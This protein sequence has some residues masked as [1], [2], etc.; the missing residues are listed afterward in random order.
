[1][2]AP[3]PG[4]H[5]GQPQLGQ[6]RV[7]G[8]TH[9]RVHEPD[10]SRPGLG[11]QPGDDAGLEPGYDAIL[12]G[13]GRVHEH[14]DVG[15]LTHGGG[16][17]QDRHRGRGQPGQAPPEHVPDAFR[18]FGHD[19]QPTLANQ[20]LRALFE[21]EGVPSGTGAQRPDDVLVDR[22]AVDG[23]DQRGHVRSRQAGQGQPGR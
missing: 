3:D 11:Q 6:V 20:Q 16:E 12:I 18:D 7:H 22:A 23:T 5:A 2:A 17:P 4:V 13:I 19:D 1:M 21:V 15:F 10:A 9:E 14:L 8:V